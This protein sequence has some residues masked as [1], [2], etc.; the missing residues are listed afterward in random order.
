MRTDPPLGRGRSVLPA[1]TITTS[2]DHSPYVRSGRHRRVRPRTLHLLDVENLVAGRVAGDAVR[3]MWNEFV[4]TVDARWEDHS[5]VAVSNR[6]A[7][8]AF[9][10]LP[11]GVR[12]V[13]GAD[14]P[15]GA[16]LALIDSVDVDWVAGRFGRVAIG[17][18][19]HIFAALA[20]E[21]R[22]RGLEVVQVIGGGRCSTELYRVCTGH[23]YL[24][25]TRHAAAVG[26]ARRSADL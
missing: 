3:T 1:M 23:L 12:R 18:G 2:S 19:D 20:G 15:D 16:D 9:L 24:P 22:H 14:E 21:L 17:S 25:R 26:R 4:D 6:N 10:A 11:A 8:A 5:T 13:V 7:T